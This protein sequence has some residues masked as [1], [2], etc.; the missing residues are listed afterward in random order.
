MKA[1]SNKSQLIIQESTGPTGPQGET[2][3]LS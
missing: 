3:Y 1:L 2:G